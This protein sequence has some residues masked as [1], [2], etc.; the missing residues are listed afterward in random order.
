MG[1]NDSQWLCI[2]L[3][4]IGIVVCHSV[5]NLLKCCFSRCRRRNETYLPSL[6]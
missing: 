3:D 5:L 4:F 6:I 1:H 2:L